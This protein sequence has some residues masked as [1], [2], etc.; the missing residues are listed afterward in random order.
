[1]MLN[2]YIS[3][4]PM[5]GRDKKSCLL[6]GVLW[7]NDI[8]QLPFPKPGTKQV[9]WRLSPRC[10]DSDSVRQSG[11]PGQPAREPFCQSEPSSVRMPAVWETAGGAGRRQARAESFPS[12]HLLCGPEAE[13]QEESQMWDLRDLVF[14]SQHSLLR[15]TR[16]FLA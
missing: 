15:Q 14:Q 7:G 13:S 11:P 5:M 9:S 6:D 12:A 4:L 2:H 8:F 16:W 10:W 3:G 1:M